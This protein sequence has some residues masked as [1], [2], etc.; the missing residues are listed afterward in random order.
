MDELRQFIREALASGRSRDEISAILVRAGWPQDEVEDGLSHYLEAD[1]PIPV[2]R[3]RYSGS[4]RDAFVYLITFVALYTTAISLGSL[5]FGII[6]VYLPDATQNRYGYGGDPFGMRWALAP[7]LVASPLYFWLARN[8]VRSVQRHPEIRT[9]VVRRWLT[10]LTLF[11]ACAVAFGTLIAVIG[12]L[13]GG[14]LALASV[15][16]AAITLLIVATVFFY[17]RWELGYGGGEAA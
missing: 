11:V 14:D 3:R 9:S 2:P 4:A 13:L 16:K 8:N 6:D 17:Y 10:Y 12:G 1:F 15:C 7:L 5:L